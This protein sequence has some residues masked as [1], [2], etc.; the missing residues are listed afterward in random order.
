M[1]KWL[2]LLLAALM[3]LSVVTTAIPAFAEEAVSGVIKVSA[4]APQGEVYH[5]ITT[6]IVEYSEPI[7]AP[8]AKDA[9]LF[10]D[11]FVVN[12]KEEYDRF[13]Y[14][15]GIIQN[16]YTNAE[17]AR[18][19][20]KAGV[21]GNYL[22][23]EL[24]PTS[25]CVYSEEEQM[26]K[27]N[28]NC[29]M[30][31]WR[32]NG[33]RSDWWR[34][35]YS[36]LKITANVD[37]LNADGKVVAAAGELPTL[38]PEDVYTPG[39]EAHRLMTIKS[40]NGKYDLYFTLALPENYD[41]AKEYPLFIHFS[42]NG[43]RV[44]P[45]QMDANGVMLPHGAILTRDN[46]SMGIYNTQECIVLSPQMWRN[47][48]EEWDANLYRVDAKYIV[49]WVMD[50]FNVDEKRVYAMSSSFGA[51]LA[52][53]FIYA[54]P[55]VLTAYI[56]GNG[57]TAATE[58]DNAGTQNLDVFKEE[59]RVQLPADTTSEYVW[60]EI[61]NN[62]NAILPEEQWID[63]AEAIYGKAIDNGTKFWVWHGITDDV[64]SI[65]LSTYVAIR[66]LC[67]KRGFTQEQIDDVLHMT[68]LE[69]KEYY[70]AG[71][72]EIHQSTRMIMLPEHSDVI[73][74]MFA[75]SK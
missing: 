36:E 21:A 37:V 44:C 15:D 20:D 66:A 13:P 75:Q 41:P 22:I 54:Y 3:L 57:C 10:R 26:W 59:L 48:K 74:W 2:S 45:E 47:E 49:D 60:T 52:S 71:V 62:P 34:N 32:H 67:Q 23:I 35:D 46:V 63:E 4:I 19:D 58:W 42:G 17:P 14:S 30:A 33:E 38:N 28:Q 18:L 53:N 24:E 16:I 69:D 25:H 50:S 29:G 11:Y 73:D 43:S 55:E 70:E 68:L 7:V 6:L 27:P 8:E 51:Y 9:F 31:T 1:K 56:Q 65:K 39:L 40:P 64:C 61:V 5:Q 12:A 72:A